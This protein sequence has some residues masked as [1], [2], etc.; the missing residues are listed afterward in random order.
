MTQTN[1]S[2]KKEFHF[3]SKNWEQD[4]RWIIPWL[5]HKGWNPQEIRIK[6]RRKNK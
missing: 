4:I 2:N 6:P 1:L 3:T 5:Q